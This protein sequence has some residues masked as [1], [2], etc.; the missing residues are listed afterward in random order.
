MSVAIYRVDAVNGWLAF[1]SSA[2]CAVRQ[3]G[4]PRR[5]EDERAARAAR[6]VALAACGTQCGPVACSVSHTEGSAVVLAGT[7]TGMFGVDLVRFA[8]VTPRHSRAILSPDDSEAFG[9]MP[10]RYRDALAWALKEAGAKATGA[11]QQYF[12]DGVHLI[13]DPL[14]GGLRVRILSERPIMLGAAWFVSGSLLCALVASSAQEPCQ[15]NS[16]A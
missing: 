13:V 8:R 1:A 3:A 4:R 9:T 14:A 12:P 16:A 2:A 11:P 6:D 15:T 10:I 7:A 5:R